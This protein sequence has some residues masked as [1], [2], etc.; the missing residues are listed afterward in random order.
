[1][2]SL[3][4]LQALIFLGPAR[5]FKAHLFFSLQGGWIFDYLNPLNSKWMIGMVLIRPGEMVWKSHSSVLCLYG[6]INYSHWAEP[7]I[8]VTE[9]SM[10]GNVLPVCPSE[11]HVLP[12][13]VLLASIF[14]GGFLDRGAWQALTPENKLDSVTKQ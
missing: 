2:F 13:C 6:S 1:M 12:V 10:H 4:E 11:T 7:W 3:S 14:G 9:D 5:M 8:A